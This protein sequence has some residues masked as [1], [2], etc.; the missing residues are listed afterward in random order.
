M[1]TLTVKNLPPMLYERLKEKAKSNRRSL[2]NEI[3]VML[4]QGLG[5]HCQ[6]ESGQILERARQVRELTILR[7]SRVLGKT[8]TR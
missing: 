1:T 6:A 8:L 2:N 3:I 5:L 4:E 7:V